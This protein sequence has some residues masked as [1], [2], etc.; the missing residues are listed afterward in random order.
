MTAL[1]QMRRNEEMRSA[2]GALIGLA[3]LIV[4]PFAVLQGLLTLEH[5]SPWHSQP[6]ELIF[7]IAGVVVGALGVWLLP[8][9]TLHR[10]LLLPPYVVVIAAAAWMSAP[11]TVCAYFGDCV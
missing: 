6:A 9:R 2:A 4:G 10:G 8:I 1:L 11:P 5:M 3:L 7:V